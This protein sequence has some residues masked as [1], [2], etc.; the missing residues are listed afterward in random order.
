MRTLAGLIFAIVLCSIAQAYDAYDPRNC[1]GADW[2]ENRIVAV[3]KV[4]A[5]PRANF[6]KSPYDDDFRAER[7]P[8]ATAACLK[9]SYLVPGDLVLVGKT[10]NGF[11]CISYQSPLATKQIW[12]NGW[13]RSAELTPVAPMP[14][15][16]PRDWIGSWHHPG[17]SIEITEGFGGRLGVEGGMTVPMPSGDFQN[18]D[19]KA[20][21]LPQKET[22]ALTDEGIMATDAECACNASNLGCWP[23]TTAAAAALVCRSPGCTV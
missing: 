22:I 18:G 2:D 19:F 12:A 13:L 9:K 10:Q 15:P 8:A 17:G 6:L 14:S 11:T 7:C 23:K 4:T 21:I 5:R 3:S 1:N 16:R 20:Q